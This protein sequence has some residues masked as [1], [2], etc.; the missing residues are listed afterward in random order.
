MSNATDKPVPTNFIG[1]FILEGI[2]LE[3]FLS[4]TPDPV[5][6]FELPGRRFTDCYGFAGGDRS[7]TGWG[8]IDYCKYGI[9]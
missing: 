1:V 2:Q 3:P 7:F 5:R 4:I 8:L 9:I 6:Q